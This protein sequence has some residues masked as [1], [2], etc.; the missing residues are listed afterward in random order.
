VLRKS[1]FAFSWDASKKI[2]WVSHK[3][4]IRVGLSG[5]ASEHVVFTPIAL[6]ITGFLPLITSWEED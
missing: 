2:A 4:Q 1:T 6:E 3:L 5:S